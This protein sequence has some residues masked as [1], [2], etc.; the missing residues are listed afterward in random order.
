MTT[1]V[2]SFNAKQYLMC[3][4]S[5]LKSKRVQGK[6]E[7]LRDVLLTQSS[8]GNVNHICGRRKTAINFFFS[9]N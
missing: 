4:K 7:D 6:D 2:E 5:Q 8:S 1:V 3:N 9:I